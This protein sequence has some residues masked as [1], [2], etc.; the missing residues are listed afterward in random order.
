MYQK[1]CSW[2]KSIDD[3]LR[4]QPLS[5]GGVGQVQVDAIALESRILYSASPI[6][7]DAVDHADT[8]VATLDPAD[9]FAS[10]GLDEN[11]M[12][13]SWLDHEDA[14]EVVRRELVVVD[15]GVGEAQQLVNDLIAHSDGTREFE[16][17]M[18]D[19]RGDGVA[20][21]SQALSEFSG[22][23]AIHLIA[24]GDDQGIQ[25]GATRLDSSSV[26]GYAGQIA[27]WASSLD[28]DADLLIY[29]CNLASSSDGRLLVEQLAALCDCDVAASD[30]LT[31]HSALGG[32]WQFEFM[33]G[34]IE[35]RDLV[36][37]EFQQSWHYTLDITSGLVGHYTF[38]STSGSTVSDSSS[39]NNDLTISGSV[40]STT[41]RD[42]SV[43][44]QFSGGSAEA[45][46]NPPFGFAVDGFS[47]SFWINTTLDPASTSK[48]IDH[49][50]SSRGVDF[51]ITSSQ[52]LYVSASSSLQ[53]DSLITASGAV[54][55]G[56]WHHVAM[57]RSGN[58]MELFVN[59]VSADTETG[60]YGSFSPF[61]RLKLGS[62]SFSGALDEVRVY[63]RSL[64]ASDV[65]E[66]YNDY[67]IANQ[68]ATG[69]PTISGT[70]E[71]FETLT[72]DVSG[73]A[74]ADGLG[75][76]SYQW[77]RDGTP[78]SLATGSQYMLTAADVGAQISVA[79]SFTDGGGNSESV[80]SASTSAVVDAPVFLV[81][82]TNN[83]G[84]GSFRQ[85][86]IDA[87][88]S[89]G[90]DTIRFDIA[91]SGP[92][93]INLTS[94]V[95]ITDTVF[96]D[97]TTEP[98]YAGA[99]SV[100][101][102]V[103]D[104]GG[105]SMDG[106]FFSSSADNSVVRGLMLRDFAYQII[107][108]DAGA[109][110]ISIVGNYIGSFS[111]SG[112]VDTSQLGG[113]G[114]VWVA[115]TD[116]IIG[117]PTL[118]DRN[119][120]LSPTNT[121]VMIDGDNN[122]VQ[123][124]YIGVNASGSYRA[125]T[126]NGISVINGADGNT[127]GG[128]TA[129]HGNVVAGWNGVQFYQHSSNTLIQ[130]NKFGVSAD[131]TNDIGLQAG[132]IFFS[133][134]GDS[135]QM[136]DNH[137]ASTQFVGIEIEGAG[138]ANVIQG[139]I[140]GTDATGTQNW[141]TG[142]SGIL[143]DNNG[144]GSVVNTL[145]GGTN[146][147]DGN[148]IAFSG[149]SFSSTHGIWSDSFRSNTFLGNSI[150]EHDIA[151]VFGPWII[152]ANDSEDVGGTLNL[153]VL[154]NVVQ[155]S[156]NLTIDFAVDLA[157]GTYRIEFFD[158]PDGVDA[159]GNTEAKTFLGFANITV[160]GAAGYETFST[161]LASTTASSVTNVGASATEYFGGSSYG[162]TSQFSPS[163]NGAGVLLVSSTGDAIDGDTSS[164]TALL[165]NR[166]TDG[167]ITLREAIIAS[168][169]TA[170]I[171]AADQIRFNIDGGGTQFINAD[172][173]PVI[174]DTVMIDGTTQNGFVSNGSRP[175]V[176][177]DGNGASGTAFQ[178]GANSDGSTLRGLVI[179]DFEHGV[180]TDVGADS[181]TIAGNYIGALD[182]SGNYASGEEITG[183]AVTLQGANATVGGFTAA[184]RNVI[185]GADVGVLIQGASATGNT[186]SGNYL[187]TAA[188]GTTAI[189][190]GSR[191]IDISGAAD[192]IIGGNTT[193]HRNVIVGGASQGIRITG[194]GSDR[195]NVLNNFI[196]T[197]ATGSALLGS[198]GVGIL[199]EQR[200]DQTEILNNVI[201]GSDAAGIEL[202]GGVSNFILDT[203]IRG[204]SIGTDS[205][206]TLN[207]G[208][209]EDGVL[210]Q[211]AV[212]GVDIGGALAGLG[213]TIAFNGA[214]LSTAAGV[215]VRSGA[216]QVEIRRNS[217]YS[218]AGL[219]IDLSGGTSNDGV[220]GN[221]V[222]D[223]DS[224]GNQRQNYAHLVSAESTSGG[225]LSIEL[226]ASDLAP[227]SYR[228]ELYA[229]AAHDAGAIEGQRYL[230]FLNVNGGDS[231]IVANISGAN[232]TS[233]EVLSLTT[234]DS[235]GNTSEFNVSS[236]TVAQ[237][238]ATGQPVIS[239]TVAED[240][241]LSVNGS[242][243]G[244]SNG[245]GTFSYQWLRDGVAVSGATGTTYTL[246]DADVGAQMSVQVS[247]TD[248]DGYSE[249]VTSSQTAAVANLNDT[250]S[251]VPTI[252]GTAAE[253]QTL[254]A[255][256]TGI[257]DDDGLGSFSYQWL[258]D[259]VGVSGA[260]SSTYTLGD[261]DVGTQVSVRV[262]YTDGNGTSETLT[263]AQTSAVTNVNDAP[264]GLPTISGT[265]TEDQTLTAVTTGI[266]DGDGLGSLSYQW[267]RGGVAISGATANTYTLGDN[268]V[269]EQISV[270]VSYT[271]GNGTSESL[272]SAQTAAVTN[273]NDTPSGLPTISGTAAED[274]TLTAVTSG[275]SDGDGLGSF[276]YQWLRDGVSISGA[277]ASTYT[278]GDADVGTQVSVRVGYTDGNGTL[279]TVTSN[280]TSSVANVNDA[281]GGSLTI[282]GTAQE[283]E[284]LAA[285]TAALS[286]NDGLGAFSY[287]WL[288]D[289]SAITGATTSTYDLVAADIGTRVSVRVS[290]TD[291]LGTAESVTSAQTG[292]VTNGFA[293]P[294]G[295]VTIAGTVREDETLSADAS[296]VADADGLGPLSYQWL[297]DGQ[298]ISGATS[299]NYTL[300]DNDS[301]SVIAVQVRYV[302]G[303][304]TQEMLQSASTQPVE[305]VN[306]APIMVNNSVSL[307]LG[308]RATITSSDISG[309]DVDGDALTFTV[310][311]VGGGQFEFAS[312]PGAAITQFTQAQIAAG[313]V[314]FAQD[315]GTDAPQW[316]I[317]AS[318]A[319]VSSAVYNS[320]SSELII[321]AAPPPSS[322]STVGSGGQAGGGEGAGSNGSGDSGTGAG[323]NSTGTGNEGAS[324]GA[325]TDNGNSQDRGSTSGESSE[326]GSLGGQSEAGAQGRRAE[327]SGDGAET[328]Q[329]VGG[330][331]GA[332]RGSAAGAAS[333]SDGATSQVGSQ[334]TVTQ[335]VVAT[336]NNDGAATGFTDSANSW[337]FA[338][339]YAS[340]NT[341]GLRV[342]FTN[343][344]ILAF[345]YQPL[346]ETTLQDMEADLASLDQEVEA[347]EEEQS[348][349]TEAATCVAVGFA[350]SSTFWMMS[351]SVLVT[352]FST[353]A[354]A[355]AKFDPIFILRSST[356]AQLSEPDSSVAEIIQKEKGSKQ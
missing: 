284:T 177:I 74:D 280:P 210:L 182:T 7:F 70:L 315:F 347:R 98:D 38:D 115:G 78:I 81:T 260:T 57:V 241:V 332:V 179:R 306:D 254:T 32:D 350:V 128:P 319:A 111:T 249:L 43:A 239:G 136:L 17:V 61:S 47:Y 342:G 11:W 288:R 154:T 124:N 218:N 237:F 88:N 302:D 94:F 95:H 277:T 294:T 166:G 276:S 134:G 300:G 189:G 295:A 16:I 193:S 235:S 42:G 143:L 162:T 109:T 250:P 349:V 303:D 297:R 92:H 323:D 121:N 354:P 66:L 8:S 76:F 146:A 336:G 64:S 58:S 184:D 31:G 75:A 273:V 313:Q 150:Y 327:V 223:L 50:G 96:I 344:D 168:N 290:Y 257:S 320:Q 171:T 72:A 174:S 198:N 204:N 65:T 35:T 233:S 346:S 243:I 201:G 5:E 265:T 311:N 13:D 157:A 117:G 101:V 312:A 209:D 267:L 341:A 330:V 69:A 12:V 2:A 299:S 352:L 73:I 91:G 231:S 348:K 163:F 308:Q 339:R 321:G 268:D 343:I 255:V 253:D 181:I 4:T 52:A 155:D 120:I 160:T 286:D 334:A 258:R 242:G 227:G 67:G 271:D 185:A 63:N 251:G 36:S 68:P 126:G 183:A 113:V 205:T 41:G 245:L 285:N 1:I 187:G 40:S 221:D 45:G 26:S 331:Q 292:T 246:G 107:D 180:A 44:Y 83:A 85:A 104:G 138:N 269:G 256:T 20:Q 28:A 222:D 252:S 133:G 142:Y 139:N 278:L 77:R 207:L 214:A 232:V 106:L 114:A 230:G 100:P 132:G 147:G 59:G 3:T 298:A 156:G 228:V 131:G 325:S 112:S 356:L 309:F 54:T 119:Y 18:L 10:R 238:A 215:A 266:S 340:G 9:G 216:T 151:V 248:G 84:A 301:G 161:S 135:N 80:I 244:D 287:Q 188:D 175:I 71:K 102:V 270:R 149:Q 46:S 158:N 333:S 240:S 178:F 86:I 318:D 317:I 6:D 274:Q 130:H 220:T 87:N 19:A 263:S 159:N 289:G 108:I 24:H 27:T 53:G 199:V 261:A 186:V 262:S 291:G 283:Y 25:L 173:L 39:E 56:G 144:S 15:P 219:G 118:A 329:V 337:D 192:N 145:V 310:S 229:T 338:H 225:A 212:T 105:G 33:V 206:G 200:A 293:S 345:E 335:L 275:I 148:T 37:E 307:V 14:A 116:N 203:I 48:V 296:T 51:S 89:A 49:S 90:A 264:S 137:I 79:V 326:S 22:I 355:W 176:V 279:E 234:T 97:G 191:A 99:G 316:S 322:G 281:P 172:I 167:L 353:S 197:D 21:I 29:G 224:G 213:N 226:D 194:E 122:V 324:D 236:V 351:S 208:N 93:V 141:G 140:I 259:G 190:F 127:I 165:G 123:G 314:V 60:N 328:Q 152:Q 55:D 247:F 304:G 282:S 211:G 196:G 164:I 153:P 34:A 217:L 125:S 82:N 110:G 202:D 23:D 30:D 169:N 305:N 170:N 103:I 62:S 195:T 129:A 272:T